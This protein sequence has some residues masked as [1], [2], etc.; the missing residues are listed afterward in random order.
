[1]IPLI[2]G[3]GSAIV[4]G[5]QTADAAGAAQKSTDASNKTLDDQKLQDSNAAKQ[6][7]DLIKRRLRLMQNPTPYKNPDVKTS[8]LGTP[9]GPYSSYLG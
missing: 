3:A 4:G 8:A 1:M 2:I 6:K 7:A 9:A 5:I